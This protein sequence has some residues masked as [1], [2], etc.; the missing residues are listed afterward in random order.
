MRIPLIAWIGILSGGL[1][2]GAE[3][4]EAQPGRP[5]FET[6]LAQAPPLRQT[7]E[8]GPVRAFRPGPVPGVFVIDYRGRNGEPRHYEF[9]PGRMVL[10]DVRS[11]FAPAEG[12]YAYSYAVSNGPRAARGIGRLMLTVTNVRVVRHPPEW[13]TPAVDEFDASRLVWFAGASGGGAVATGIQ[14]GMTV[15]GF[16]YESRMLPGPAL[17][18]FRAIPF[19]I[20]E[21]PDD[22]PDD[23][24][25]ELMQMMRDSTVRRPVI[26]A[27][28]P[29]GDGRD[30]MS[31]DTFLVTLEQFYL[32]P[33]ERSAHPGK[34]SLMQGMAE[35]YEHASNA[36]A[37]PARAALRKLLTTQT[38]GLD[39][40]SAELDRALRLCLEYALM[41]PVNQP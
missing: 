35:V 11:V 8:P 24:T 22:L 30:A 9:R 13:Q 18:E 31:L 40:W 5:A 41:L 20:P 34:R 12:G 3:C 19:G 27:V 32:L 25:I 17:A 2:A 4:V 10:P 14:P 38:A 33:L 7:M 26:S 39:P 16:S 36:K 37:G 23:A 6:A 28:I 21:V 15:D 29:T 1:M